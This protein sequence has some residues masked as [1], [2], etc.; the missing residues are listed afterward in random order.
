MFQIIINWLK[1]FWTNCI[2]DDFP[3]DWPQ[4][5][6][7]CNAGS[8]DGCSV[9]KYPD[10][11]GDLDEEKNINW[12]S[13]QDDVALVGVGYQKVQSEGKK[14]S[15]CGQPAHPQLGYNCVDCFFNAAIDDPE[16]DYIIGP[17]DGEIYLMPGYVKFV[18]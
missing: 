3:K 1:A 6:F 7:M 16:G 11:L 17:N 5:C 14:C 13:G 18:K 12:S 4:E 9:R 10:S 8:C 15:Y 2:C